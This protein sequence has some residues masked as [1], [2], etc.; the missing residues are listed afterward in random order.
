[1]H[2]QIE[3]AVKTSWDQYAPLTRKHHWL[4]A[5]ANPDFKRKGYPGKMTTC[6]ECG[7]VRITKDFVHYYLLDVNGDQW[8]KTE[9]LCKAL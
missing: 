7:R 1:M 9:P 2:K 4:N 6:A 5:K 3:K 8:T